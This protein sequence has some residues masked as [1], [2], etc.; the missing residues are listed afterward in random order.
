MKIK[1]ILFII[2]LLLVKSLLGKGHAT[3]EVDYYQE[4]SQAISG[5]IAYPDN[6]HE[7]EKKFPAVILIH[8]W[9]GLN[10]DIKTKARDYAKEGYV[11]LAVDL[12]NGEK[13][14]KASEARKLAGAVRENVEMAFAN[15]AGAINFLKKDNKIDPNRIAAIG[16][17]F[18]GGWSYQ[19]AKNNLGV[20]A[21]VIYYGF[22]NPA[23][24]LEQMRAT[25]LGHFAEKDRSITIDNVKE[26]QIKL[27]NLKG[28][29]AVY[30][31]PNT[32]HGFASRKGENPIYSE[33]DAN[34]AWDRTL[35]FLNKFLKNN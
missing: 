19:M 3:G 6:Y 1:L 29:H 10:E 11:A 9:W 17:C 31:Y 5:Y 26:F 34:L 28:E 14:T 8:E 2:T 7:N 23:D 15:L 20:V 12:Y 33:K 35:T 32:S 4:G 13:T 22:F 27:K 21:S 30:I 18:G 24:D 16:W 25:I